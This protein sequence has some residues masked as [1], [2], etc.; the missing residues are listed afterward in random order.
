MV[1]AKKAC[2][3]S[4]PRCKRCPLVLKRLERAGLAER[5]PGTRRYTLAPELSK[6]EL[7]DARRRGKQRP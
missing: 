4:R 2:C 5:K 7:R 6:R 3:S 1:K